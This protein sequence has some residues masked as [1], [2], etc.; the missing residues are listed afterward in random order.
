VNGMV[1]R[2]DSEAL[3]VPSITTGPQGMTVLAGSNVALS[4]EA[5]GTTPLRYYWRLEGTG[6]LNATNSTLTMSN[7][8]VAQAV[9]I[10]WSFPITWV[11]SPVRRHFCE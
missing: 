11:L 10:K 7:V 6:I 5:A 1:A 8:T 2:L 9:I 4:V 3:I